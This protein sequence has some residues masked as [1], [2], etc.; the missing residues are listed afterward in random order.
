MYVVGLIRLKTCMLF[1]FPL[2]LYVHPFAGASV[3]PANELHGPDCFFSV[4][5]LDCF[6]ISVLRL[7]CFFYFLSKD[8][9]IIFFDS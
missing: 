9:C 8:L 6:Y 5:G 4:L 2:M 1:C 7:D 3:W